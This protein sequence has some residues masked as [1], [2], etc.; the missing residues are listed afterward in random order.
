[1][2][3]HSVAYTLLAAVLFCIAT[4]GVT[5]APSV[6]IAAAAICVA[7]VGV[8]HGGLDHWVGRRL[9]IPR[10]GSAW[11]IAFLPTYLVVGS[12]V[13]VG[14]VIAPVPTIVAFFA[15]SAWHFGREDHLGHLQALAV[16]GLIIWIPSL[17]RPE[18]MEALLQTLILSNFSVLAGQVVTLTQGLAIAL[19]PV[20]AWSLVRGEGRDHAVVHVATAILGFATPILW[21]F[22][23]FFCGWHSIRGLSRMRADES[24]SWRRFSA[25]V[26]PLSV[27]AV[28]LVLAVGS[29]FGAT[30]AEP[31]TQ[32]RLLF[33]GLA[34]IAVPH[35]FLHELESWVS[36]APIK[37]L[38]HAQ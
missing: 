1:M 35:L 9:L 37:E 18:E 6:A 12:C 5:I 4:A 13:A 17:A 2:I 29:L 8:P 38:V 32:V 23:A 24:L 19:L 36:S 30:L 26:M 10:L 28:V 11:P 15:A 22:T 21:S 34:S 16:G 3:S 27:G 31:S 33:I 25:S 14:W 20:A 7:V